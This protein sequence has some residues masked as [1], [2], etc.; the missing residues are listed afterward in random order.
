MLPNKIKVAGI[1][2]QI[3]EVKEIDDDP[4]MIGSYIYQKSTIK[5]KSGMSQDKKEQTLV[6]EMLHACFN[7]AGFDEQDEDVINRV[8]IVLYQVLKDNDLSFGDKMPRLNEL[9]VHPN[10]K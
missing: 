8:G 10:T 1:D 9:M 4:S 6:H 2:Y 5:I 7:E 3:Q